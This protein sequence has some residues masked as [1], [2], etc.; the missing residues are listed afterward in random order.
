MTNDI[1]GKR[2]TVMG[3]GILGGGVAVSRYLASHGGIVTVTDMRPAEQLQSSI[4]QL[5]DLPITYHLG[6]HDEAD[7]T[8][9]NADVV[10]RNPG[11]RKWSSYLELARKH[12]VPIHMEMSLFFSR[13]AAPVLGITGTKGKTT[14]STLCGEIMRA[15]KPN[16][17][18][19]GNMGVGALDLVDGILPDQ[20]V[21][22]ELSS[23]QLE[24]MDEHQLGPHVGV[25]TNISPDHLDAYHDYED[26]AA[27]KRTI[28]HHLSPADYI[29]FN[30]D[31]SDCAKIVSETRGIPLPFGLDEPEG[32]GGWVA[33][34]QL[35]VR[36]QGEH[37]K[38]PL[39]TQLSLGGENGQRNVLAASVACLA[40]GAPVEAIAQGLVSFRGVHS[41]LEEVAR[42]NNV[43]YVNDTSATAPAAAAHAINVL[44][45]IA[46]RVHLI[47]GGADKQT[48]LSPFADALKA[49]TQVTVSLLEGTAT[50]TLEAMLQERGISYAGPFGSMSEGFAAANG[51][52]GPGDVVALVPGCASFGMFR[53]EFDRGD[54]FRAEVA[55]LLES[56]ND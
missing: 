2:F 42:V 10:I 22:L 39:P 20:S 28:A 17:I 19:A 45:G 4:D 41:R 7:F 52:A 15:W 16:A 3:L 47:A 18:L 26:Y 43:L 49:D 8:S 32:D 55:K 1:A 50:P 12:G 30:A 44:T 9:E 25:I 40:Y 37:V 56:N 27:T 35:H 34:G 53:N 54:Q 31:D 33:G 5:A 13:V 38:L 24:A 21:V 14:V 23:W 11:V 48:D 51:Q 36:F 29:V 46:N 6:A